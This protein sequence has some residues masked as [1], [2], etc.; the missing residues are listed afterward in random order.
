MI[1]EQPM[2]RVV[3]PDGR[4]VVLLTAVDAC[5]LR[6]ELCARWPYQKVF[7]PRLVDEW[8]AGIILEEKP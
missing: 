5:T 7:T 6:D 1:D 8:G 3:M 2:Y 4:Q